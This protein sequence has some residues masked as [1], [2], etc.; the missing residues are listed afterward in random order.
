MIYLWFTYDLPMIYHDLPT[1]MLN[2]AGMFT[3]IWMILFGQ[4]LVNIP[5]MEHMG[6]ENSWCDVVV[7]HGLSF[8]Q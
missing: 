3:Y 6:Y 7:Y 2:G 1:H 5:Y 8:N 4:R